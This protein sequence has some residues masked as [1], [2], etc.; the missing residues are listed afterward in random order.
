MEF[1]HFKLLF[2]NHA[3]KGLII[4]YLSVNKGEAM[5]IVL[6]VFRHAATGEIVRSEATFVEVFVED[7]PPFC[8]G[9]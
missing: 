5:V 7:F 8:A 2:L 1:R 9:A 3:P 4:R 6:R